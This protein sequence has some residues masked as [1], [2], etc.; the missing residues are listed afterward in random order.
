MLLPTQYGFRA[1]RSTTDAIFILRSSI[2]NYPKNVFCCFIVLKAA[3]HWIDRSM[4]FR[5]L[6][7][8][9]GDSI[10]VQILKA[11]YTGTSTNIRGTKNKFQTFIDYR[12][13]GLESP[14]IFNIYLDFVLRCAEAAVLKKFPDT[15]LHYSYLIPGRCSNREQRSVSGLSGTARMRMLLYADDIVLLCTNIA[16]LQKIDEF[17]D[18]TFKRFGL[19]KN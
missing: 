8:R 5:I 3:Y 12:Q 18:Q 2:E 1:N 13:G 11:L 7:I 9:L 15:G 6:E 10:L 14:I 16:E 19:Q 4:I 17:Y